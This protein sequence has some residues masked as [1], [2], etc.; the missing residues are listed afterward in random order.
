MKLL[1]LCRSQHRVFLFAGAF[2]LSLLAAPLAHAFTIDDQSN[3]PAGGS[4]RYTDPDSRL[5]GTGNDGTTVYKQGNT[6]LKFGSQRQFDDRKY[7]TENI[8]NPNG[9]PGDDR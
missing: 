3:A 6:T 7:N 4:A 8:F 2:G 1:T 5:T 9:R